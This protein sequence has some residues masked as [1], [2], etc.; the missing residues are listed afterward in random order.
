MRSILLHTLLLPLIAAT[1]T[2]AAAGAQAAA[3]RVVAALI[4]GRG[5]DYYHDEYAAGSADVTAAGARVSVAPLVWRYG[6]LAL[7][8]SAEQHDHV[9]HYLV[10]SPRSRVWQWAVGPELR[11]GPAPRGTPFEGRAS[12]FAGGVRR[13]YVGALWPSVVD[14]LSG[15]TSHGMYGFELGAGVRVLGVGLGYALRQGYVRGV[16]VPPDPRVDLAPGAAQVIERRTA[17]FRRHGAELSYG[18]SW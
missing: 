16:A 8:G 18:F 17:S 14:E 3:P 9:A 7:A 11:L 5:S 15:P 4:G 1:T 6:A 13:S 10:E 12:A 2:A